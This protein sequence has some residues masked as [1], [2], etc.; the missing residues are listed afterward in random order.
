MKLRPSAPPRRAR[1]FSLVELMI[2]IA[3]VGVMAGL[4][5]PNIIES[6][7][8][9]KAISSEK[10]VG[11]FITRARNFARTTGCE[12]SVTVSNSAT[13]HS[14]TYQTTET[15]TSAPCYDLDGLQWTADDNLTIGSWTLADGTDTNQTTT[16]AGT[17]GVL[18]FNSEG[19]T[20]ENQEAVLSV[21]NAYGSARTIEVWPLIG[22][23][24]VRLY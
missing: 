13:P 17:A 19:G 9:Q 15:D 14:I 7:Q 1:G 21:S 5:L 4:A 16:P 6:I 23:I 22:S 11:D 2:A 24:N 12:T 18:I 8:R 10:E 3:I 20:N